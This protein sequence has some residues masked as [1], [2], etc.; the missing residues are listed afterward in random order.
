MPARNFFKVLIHRTK[1]QRHHCL[2]RSIAR[3]NILA[4]RVLK[5]KLNRSMS[6]TRQGIVAFLAHQLESLEEL[7]VGRMKPEKH[8]AHR[9]RRA[10]RRPCL[11]PSPAVLNA[12]SHGAR[13]SVVAWLPFKKM[14]SNRLPAPCCVARL[15]PDGSCL[16]GIQAQGMT[17]IAPDEKREPFTPP[18]GRPVCLVVG[19]KAQELDGVAQ[20]RSSCDC[21]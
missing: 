6:K 11:E 13:H 9:P 14:P 17:C 5:E 4:Q 8:P 18:N 21:R 15:V 2:T 20:M 16:D 12:V 7:I 10:D 3:L 19:M 1:K